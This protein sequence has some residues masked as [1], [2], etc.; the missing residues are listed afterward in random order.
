[1]T[2]IGVEEF[3]QKIDGDSSVSAI[4]EEKPPT[5][6]VASTSVGKKKRKHRMV[7]TATMLGES[8]GCAGGDGKAR[9]MNWKPQN[10]LFPE[11]G[12]EGDG[13]AAALMTP[14]GLRQL[15]WWR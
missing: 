1:M 14:F 3:E 4:D 12:E 11:V 15:Q 13:T 10:E 9:A 2:Q 7:V 5:S 8:A 6:M